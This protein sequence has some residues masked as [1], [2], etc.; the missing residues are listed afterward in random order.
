VDRHPDRLRL[1]ESIG[2][3]AIDDSKGSPVEQ[4]VELTKGKGADK[5][6]ECVGYQAHDP[7]GQEKPNSTMN[8]LFGCV[9]ATG[10]IGV[11]GVFVLEDPK[12]PDKLAKQGQLAINWGLFFE[13]GLRVGA[14][15]TNVKAYNRRLCTLIHRGIATPSFIVSHELPLD[16]AP[17]AY[18]R[19]DAREDGWTKVVLKPA[20]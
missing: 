3:I 6:C 7:H 5:G 15:Q 19:F 14:G 4:V 8:S 9:R 16:E 2:A 11:V 10:Q 1:A 18:Q 20:A 17:D 12:S 13:K